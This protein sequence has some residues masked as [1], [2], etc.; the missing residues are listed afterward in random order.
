MAEDKSTP[1]PWAAD[2]DTR[3]GYEWNTFI[4]KADDPNI[5]I[6]FMSVGDASEANAALIV[7]AV[8]SHDAMQEC[9]EALDGLLDA[10]TRPGNPGLEPAKGRAV[11]ALAKLEMAGV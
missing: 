3:E 11:D 9:V 8:N 6:A 4:V 1:R 5:R 7:Q 2:P 10:I